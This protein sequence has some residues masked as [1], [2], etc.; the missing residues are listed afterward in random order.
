M[1]YLLLIVIMGLFHTQAFRNAAWYTLF[2]HAL[3]LY[4]IMDVSDVD[5][6][7]EFC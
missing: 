6:W 2:A 4:R 5:V 1:S 7:A 3:N